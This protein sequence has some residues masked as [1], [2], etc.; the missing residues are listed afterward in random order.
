MCQAY[1][2]GKMQSLWLSIT[3]AAAV[4][5]TLLLKYW[6]ATRQMRHVAAH[7]S[8]VPAAFATTVSLASHQKAA[9]YTV[10]RS[11]LGLMSLAVGTA[12][13]IGW[14]L[15]GGLDCLFIHI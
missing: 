6:L 5:L 14:T 9:D 10:V 13:L 11:R 4:A 1:T 7:R 3:F 15:L 2:D 8:A 12:L